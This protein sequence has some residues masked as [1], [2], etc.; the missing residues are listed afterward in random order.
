MPFSNNSK[1]NKPHNKSSNIL[2]PFFEFVGEPMGDPFDTPNDA[3][4]M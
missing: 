4:T 3:N 1:I 2:T